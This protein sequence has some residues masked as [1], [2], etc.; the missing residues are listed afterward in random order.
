MKRITTAL[1]LLG[2]SYGCVFGQANTSDQNLLPRPTGK[3]AVGRVTYHWI[4][5]AR[6]EVLASVQN[7][8]RE[9]MVDIWYPAETD[10]AHPPAPYLPDLPIAAKLLDES[11]VKKEFGIAYTQIING[12]LDTHAQEAATF[13]RN[14]KQC[15][16]LIFSHGLGVLRS[17]YTSLLEDL[18]SHGYVVLSIAHTY[19]TRLV[20]FPDGRIV[21]FENEKRRA[22]SGSEAAG[23]QYGNERLR[24]WAADIRFVIDQLVRYNRETDFGSP[25]S[26][27]LDLKHIG[28]LGHSDGGRA[29][30]LACQTD[31]RVRACLDMDGVADNLPFYRD[32]QGNTMKQPFLLFIRKRNPSPPTDE[33]LK[34]M[35][36][37]RE[38]LR[39][40]IVA[41]DRK[42]TEL[43]KGMP[44]GSYRVTFGTPEV[45][46]MSFSD[47]PLLENADK[48]PQYMDA[49][50]NIQ[51]IREYT[52]AFFDETLRQQKNDL[53]GQK[54]RNGS[55]LQV[56]WFP[57]R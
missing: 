20:S 39:K 16:V 37:S 22:N 46:H 14:F 45:N 10:P 3:Y 24:I 49:L 5:S 4:D 57:P 32:V 15:P 23:I 28:A 52:L 56:E 44:A 17:E 38:G 7:A 43:L 41:V 29:A 35:G 31:E 1:A 34:K 53:L 18:A 27:H 30:A 13:A 51:L 33:E 36:Y 50:H 40:L 25:L 9:L 54:S 2:L 47:L 8:N 55:S 48:E 11:E 6:S 21:R 19:D 26:G 42:Q 12:R